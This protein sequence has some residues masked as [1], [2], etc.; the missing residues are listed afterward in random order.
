[1]RKSFSQYYWSVVVLIATLV[2]LVLIGGY[3]TLAMTEKADAATTMFKPKPLDV[4]LV[5]DQSHSMFTISDPSQVITD[6]QGRPIGE[7]PPV[8]QLAAQY[9]VDYL[10]VDQIPSVE[11]RVGII[12]FG[13]KPELAAPLTNVS[14]DQN[15]RHLH[16]IL[17]ATP[18]DLHW[19]DTDAAF[20]EAY[21]VLFKSPQAD[22]S[23]EHVVVFLSDG[24]PQIIYP[25]PIEDSTKKDG[26]PLEG[27]RSYYL[28]HK[29]IIEQFS[30]KGVRFYTIIIAKTGYV[31]YNDKALQ[32]PKMAGLGFKNFANLWQQAA[33]ATGGDYFRLSVGKNNSLKRS[34]LL[35]IYHAILANLLSI[36]PLQRYQ[37]G[38]TAPDQT[39][40]IT[41]GKCRKLLITVQKGESNTEVSLKTPDNQLI[42]P[43]TVRSTYVIYKVENP[44][45]GSWWLRFQ[46]G[47]GTNYNVSLDCADI[48]LQARFLSPGSSFQQ[49]K[50]M[51]IAVKLVSETG[52]PVNDALVGVNILLPDGST[53]SLALDNR[54]QGLYQKTFTETKQEGKYQLSLEGH[55]G[56]KIAKREKG[57]SLLAVPYLSLI[58]PKSGIQLP[59]GTLS[60]EAGVKVACALASGDADISNGKATVRT[61]LIRSDG[62]K[63]APIELVD[64]GRNGDHKA[65]DAVFTGAFSQVQKGA[66]ALVV[67]LAVPALNVQDH[68]KEQI[69]V[70]MPPTKTPTPTETPVPTATPTATPA[71]A[72][73]W[74]G[75]NNITVRAGTKG[76]IPLHFNSSGLKDGQVVRVKLTGVP[77]G[78]ALHTDR[79]QILPGKKDTTAVLHFSVA[80]E[81]APA[82]GKSKKVYAGT[83]ELTYPDGKTK[84]DQISFTVLPPPTSPWAY[85]IILVVLLAIVGGL[86]G[87]YV[88]VHGRGQLVGRLVYDSAPEGTDTSDIDLYGNK[89]D[90]T[91][92]EM[93]SYEEGETIPEAESDD[94][95]GLGGYDSYE[96]NDSVGPQDEPL[97]ATLTFFAR[98]GNQE[99]VLKVTESNKAVSVN[100]GLLSQG[101]TKKL[102]DGDIIEVGSYKLHY[103]YLGVSGNEDEGWQTE[104]N[105]WD[106]GEYGDY[107][108]GDDTGEYSGGGFGDSDQGTG[109]DT[110]SSGD[111]DQGTEYDDSGNDGYTDY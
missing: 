30:E 78:L 47:Q 20:E 94:N 72:G 49:C 109:Y 102:N 46:G 86:L 103:E 106:T 51:P 91:L 9:F 104:E 75:K 26:T 28:R 83:L 66:Y 23:H 60:V 74:V 29:R 42:P 16:D 35:A 68:I 61:Y 97:H 32:D 92:D 38:V 37:G 99:A 70:G 84:H 40:P 76:E 64:D 14:T 11:N 53:K 56:D 4:I 5:V 101:E 10:H 34:D 85:I 80:K 55:Q 31:D 2:I 105:G 25:W 15:V 1:M 8:R 71:N 110:G 48:T 111:Y 69:T 12:Y 50:P 3:T 33:T 65:G 39:V 93:P 73:H 54:G 36:S 96:E 44:P 107:T 98:R 18:P 19:T 43:T 63:T 95:D 59:G 22:S 88:F 87:A 57:V 108:E 13:E 82:K 24:L 21:K 6:T 27:K 81:L 62:T 77:A 90:L 41:V 7:I 58:S 17:E 52:E 67:D 100:G 45:T 89:Y 79:V